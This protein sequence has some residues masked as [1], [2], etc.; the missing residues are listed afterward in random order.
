MFA[1]D[2]RLIVCR[3]LS[4]RSQLFAWENSYEKNEFYESRK[5]LLKVEENT[6]NFEGITPNSIYQIW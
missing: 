4:Y 6:S 3:P 5:K 2:A 1:S